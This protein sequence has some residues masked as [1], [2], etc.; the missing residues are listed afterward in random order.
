MVGPDT[1]T[2][3]SFLY[4]N[5]MPAQGLRNIRGWND[6]RSD[7]NCGF[8]CIAQLQYNAQEEWPRVRQDLLQELTDNA[9]LY[10]AEMGARR[11]LEISNAL[12]W[13]AGS[14]VDEDVYWFTLPDMGLL[15]ATTYQRVF[16]S[17]VRHG[18]YTYLPLECRTDMDSASPDPPPVDQEWTIAF[19]NGSHY[20]KLRVSR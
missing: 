16:S 14:C 9:Y 1:S 8:R 12:N 4:Q 20:I 2:G 10:I 17:Y 15:T 3:N 6:V 13:F 7:G 19:V 11:L 18:S 5:Q